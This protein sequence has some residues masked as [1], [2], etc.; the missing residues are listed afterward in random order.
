MCGVS[1]NFT[2]SP[3]GWREPTSAGF[4]SRLP[5]CRRRQS[6]LAASKFSRMGYPPPPGAPY[7]A[8]PPPPQPPLH[9]SVPPTTQ[10]P[11]ATAP[12]PPPAA[13]AIKRKRQ[14]NHLVQVGAAGATPPSFGSAPVPSAKGKK[15]T[16][17]GPA[18][19]QSIA[20]RGRAPPLP[21][22]DPDI[23]IDGEAAGHSYNLFDET[24]RR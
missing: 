6:V 20:S 3:F 21:S 1:P 4:S 17:T 8:P 24:A 23:L 7:H 16:S 10:T 13:A 11:S 9:P 5:P 12:I 14:G 18:G 2:E 22:A 19:A 15:T